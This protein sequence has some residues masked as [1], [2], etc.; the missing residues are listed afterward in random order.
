MR[1]PGYF[2]AFCSFID[3]SGACFCAQAWVFDEIWRLWDLIFVHRHGC[4]EVFYHVCGGVDQFLTY[5][6]HPR[7]LYPCK[8]NQYQLPMNLN[9]SWEL[10]RNGSSP[11]KGRAPVP[12]Q[13]FF[14]YNIKKN[15]SDYRFLGLV[16]DYRLFLVFWGVLWCLWVLWAISNWFGTPPHPV[17]LRNQSISAPDEPQFEL[18]AGKGSSPF[19]GVLGSSGE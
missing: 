13:T 5:L 18:G 12:F 4:F 16:S 3:A 11:F 9:S 17:S 6:E 2:K 19:K 7:T 10:E 14:F 8:I 15:V 1:R